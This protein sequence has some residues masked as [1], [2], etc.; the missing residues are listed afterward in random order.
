MCCVH[1]CIVE[2]RGE[3]LGIPKQLFTLVYIV[4]TLVYGTGMLYFLFLSLPLSLSLSLSLS[5]SP[6]LHLHLPFPPAIQ[7]TVTTFS[8]VLGVVFLVALLVTIPAI[9]MVIY[10]RHKSK[11][12]KTK[13]G[14]CG[15]VE[16]STQTED[17]GDAAKVT[18]IT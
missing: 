7:T 8:T 2:G 3:S 4:S 17:C 5:S 9:G 15:D 1:V 10:Y 6:S 16:K 12:Q 18:Y 14:P 13:V 11:L